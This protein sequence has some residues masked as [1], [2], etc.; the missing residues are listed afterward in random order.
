LE[1]GLAPGQFSND[2]RPNTSNY[3]NGH[4]PYKNIIGAVKIGGKGSASNHHYAFSGNQS[5]RNDEPVIILPR[6]V[7]PLRH[8]QN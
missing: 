1:N 8:V 7:S 5:R 6:E 2:W 3:E 4:F